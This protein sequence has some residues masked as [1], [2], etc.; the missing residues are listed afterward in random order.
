MELNFYS[1]VSFIVIVIELS[2]SVMLFLNSSRLSSKLAA[3]VIVMHTLWITLESLFHGTRDSGLATA[4]LN[5]S[6]Y[7]GDML[8][9]VFLFFSLSFPEDS[10]PN[11]KILLTLLIIQAC[12]VPLYATGLIAYGAFEVGGFQMWGWKWGPLFFVFHILFFGAWGTG[13]FVLYKKFIQTSGE[14]AKNLIFMLYSMVLSV[15]PTVILNI[16]LPLFNSFS[17]SWIGSIFSFLW[18]F[19]FVF[20]IVRND[21]AINVKALFSESLVLAAGVIL[22]ANVFINENADTTTGLFSAGKVMKTTIFLSFFM[23]GYLLIVNILRESE[24]KAKI[25]QLNDELKNFNINLEDKVKERNLEL[26]VSKKHTEIVI[27]NLALGII[28]HS[29]SFTILQINTAAEKLLN[30]TREEVVGKTILADEIDF[31]ELAKIIHSQDGGE[32]GEII[33]CEVSVEQP[34]YRNIQ[35]TNIPIYEIPK[36]HVSGY[37]KLLRDVTHEKAID[38]EKN[39]FVSIVAHQLLTPLENIH[40]TIEKI[41]SKG[42]NDAQKSLIERTDRSTSKLHQIAEDLLIAARIEEKEFNLIFSLNDLN[43]IV[44]QQIEKVKRKSEQKQISIVFNNETPH[45]PPFMFDKEKLSIAIKNVLK[46]A[47]DYTPAGKVVTITLRNS[48]VGYISLVIQDSGIGIPKEDLGR[49]FTKFYRSKKALLMETD[50]S[51]LG[52][53]ITKNIVDNHGGTIT[54]ASEENVGVTVEVRL[55]VYFD[56]KNKS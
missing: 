29:S 32:S 33:S 34:K 48:D 2:L 9:F 15:V 36:I 28:E 14:V 50:R 54:V 53:Y 52:L 18:I 21:H 39:E 31:K 11:K 51:G 30:I 37:V 41:L 56:I 25:A 10:K 47:V 20:G 17:Y 55:P 7:V 5:G 13:I 23:V 42:L 43:E 4:I 27:E 19:A 40:W 6:L 16:I 12:V 49:L 24:Q 1:L 46:N 38:R 45:L 22:F 3:A 26:G 44:K 35:I 8:P